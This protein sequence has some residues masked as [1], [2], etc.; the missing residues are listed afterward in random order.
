MKNINEN[1]V[2]GLVM[3]VSAFFISYVIYDLDRTFSIRYN[4]KT[5][6]SSYRSENIFVDEYN[7]VNFVQYKKNDSVRICGD[8]EIIRIVKNDTEN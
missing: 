1:L 5:Y 8:Y 6:N 4:I 3:I 2:I 7:C